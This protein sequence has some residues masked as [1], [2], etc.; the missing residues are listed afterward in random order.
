MKRTVSL[1]LL[2]A[3]ALDASAED[4]SQYSIFNP[5]PTHLMREFATDRPDKTEAAYTVDAGHFQHETDIVNAVFNT[6]DGSSEST[7]LFVAPN[8]K[9]G[10]TNSTD[11][12]LVVQSYAYS[13]TTNPKQKLSGSGDLIVRLKQNLWGN[14][15]GT[16]AMA[17]MP[18]VKVP[19][20]RGELGNDSVE[21]G[22]ILPFALNIF[23]DVGI[24][25]MQQTDFLRK[26]DDSGYYPQFV[27]T[28]TV[29]TD[30][31]DSIGVYG[32]IFSALS[33]ESGHQVTLDFGITYSPCDNVQFDMGVNVGV[34]DSAD[35]LNP[36][37]GLSQRF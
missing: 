23:E 19:T 27:H 2:S 29:G 30:I 28:A 7:F 34:T 31:T 25:L 5:T 14:D 12:Q 10:L 3:L 26:D 16:T 21:G 32:E 24:G 13:R 36:F 33:R 4:K 20:N 9:V 18:Y 17:A 11:L 1:F 35:D 37:L 6:Q 22:L 8:L 15:G